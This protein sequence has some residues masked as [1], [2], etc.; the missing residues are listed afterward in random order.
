MFQPFAL[1]RTSQFDS[2]VFA[3]YWRIAQKSTGASPD[4]KESLK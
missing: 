1:N 4:H 2:I 3:G